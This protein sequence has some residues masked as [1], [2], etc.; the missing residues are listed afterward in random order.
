MGTKLVQLGYSVRF[1]MAQQV[2]NVVLTAALAD[3]ARL[4]GPLVKCDLLI[5][6]ASEV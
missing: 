5:L 1:V 2:A 6:Q 3:L 4:F